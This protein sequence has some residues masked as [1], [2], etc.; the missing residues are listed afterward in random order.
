MRAKLLITLA[1][2]L[3]VNGGVIGFGSIFHGKKK[4]SAPSEHAAVVTVDTGLP[5]CK[6]DIDGQPEGMTGSTGTL[7]IQAVE[8]GDH[9]LHVRCPAKREI[10]RF[11]APRPGEKLQIA[12]KP[13][14]AGSPS[15]DVSPLEVAESEMRLRRMVR[16]AVQL[17][18][19]GQFQEAVKLLREATV[20]DPKNADLHRELGITFLLNHDWERARVEML[21]AIHQDPES[22]EAHSG[23]GYAYEKLGNLAEALKQYHICTQLDPDDASY[24]QHYIEVLGN[25]YEQKAQHKH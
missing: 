15:A 21:E 1:I 25:L 18:A 17:R 6:A 13:I 3:I 22:A 10:S 9:Y 23:L 20:L 16:Q 2:L 5:Q 11:M 4:A 14:L 24:Q 12:I 7:T 19:A 8:P